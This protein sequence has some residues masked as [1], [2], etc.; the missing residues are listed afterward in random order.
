MAKKNFKIVFVGGSGL[1][2]TKHVEINLVDAGAAPT[3]GKGTL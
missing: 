2:G 3:D 1:I